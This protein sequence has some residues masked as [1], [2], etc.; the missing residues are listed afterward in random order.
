MG[1]ICLDVHSEHVRLVSV[2]RT[3]CHEEKER[4]GDQLGGVYPQTSG[5]M[6]VCSMVSEVWQSSEW[7]PEGIRR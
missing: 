6:V 3:E 5:V 2:W 1:V 4:L 7:I